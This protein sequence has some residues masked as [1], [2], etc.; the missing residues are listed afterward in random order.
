MIR[1]TCL[2][3][4]AFSTMPCLTGCVERTLTVTSDPTDAMVTLNDEQ[5]GRTPVTVS[6]NWYGDYYVRLSKEG[7]QTLQ[8]HR[9]LKRPW[10][11]RFPFDFFAQ[12]RPRR[13]SD[14][15][16]WH[17]QLAE[18]DYPTRSDLIEKAMEL[19]KRVE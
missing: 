7:R 11:D 12:V 17:F 3:V 13:I 9:E 19:R 18:E 10:Y 4:C 8:T 15:H 1:L 5:I 6:F 14:Q 2:L 16:V